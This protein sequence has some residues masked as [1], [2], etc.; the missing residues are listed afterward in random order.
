M[1]EILGDQWCTDPRS[2]V[3]SVA[4]T[5]HRGGRRGN[6][7]TLIPNMKNPLGYI[8]VFVEICVSHPFKMRILV[9]SRVW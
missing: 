3:R 5:I 8:F 6:R 1:K 2:E 9:Q 4:P 7:A